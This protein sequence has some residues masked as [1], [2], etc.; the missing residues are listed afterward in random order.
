MFAD[1]ELWIN[2]LASPAVAGSADGYA[3]QLVNSQAGIE[4]GTLKL[5]L[6]E[7]GF[8]T[9]LVQVHGV[10]AA[11]DV[12]KDFGKLLFSALFNSSIEQMWRTS[13]G[14]VAGG[15]EYAGTR[16]NLLINPPELSELPWE[17]LYDPV[18]DDYLA[19]SSSLTLSRYLPVPEPPALVIRQPLRVLIVAQNPPGLKHTTLPP[20]DDD[21]V[22]SLVTSV[23]GLGNAVEHKL[24]ESPTVTQIQNELQQDYHVLHYLGHGEGGRL[25]MTADDGQ[26]I[27]VVTDDDF[28]T[29]FAGRRTLRLIVLNACHSSQKDDGSIF[30]GV[31]PAL[32]R[33]RIPAVVAMQYRF[34]QM[35]TAGRFSKAFYQALAN[36][37]SAD[38]AVN[39][40]RQALKVDFPNDRD[41]STPVLYLGTR[42]PQIL[43]LLDQQADQTQRNLLLVQQ[44]AQQ[45]A[46]AEAALGAL[47]KSFAD[48]AARHREL[49]DLLELGKRIQDVREEFNECVEIVDEA[50]ENGVLRVKDLNKSWHSL[51]AGAL[52]RLKAMVGERFASKPP[53]FQP[54]V[55]QATELDAAGEAIPKLKNGIRAVNAELA[56]A[57]AAVRL[58][59]DKAITDLLA[60][61]NQTLGKLAKS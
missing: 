11:P 6:S 58:D 52:T 25:V 21:E 4:T 53:W 50:G 37:K 28:A 31:G 54:L 42:N 39:E 14:I 13:Q 38:L 60:L 47:Q 1:F 18:V 7:E 19:T 59:L 32:V 41:W 23:E 16:L 49:A 51:A 5:D 35:S 27:R 56:K 44:V 22:A 48:L 20:L 29:L 61:S 55:Q 10:G 30:A 17:L 24:L 2:N 15:N 34:V 8:N 36:G 3:V 40:A 26:Q 12:R 33:K 45:S 43:N 57:E 46:E 9:S